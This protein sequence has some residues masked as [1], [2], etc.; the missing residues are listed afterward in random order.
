[1][2]A[3]IM[4]VLTFLLV[5]GFVV[6][7]LLIGNLEPPTAR[8]ADLETLKLRKKVLYKQIKEAE[9]EF[10]IGIL[11]DE[12]FAQTRN[13]LKKEV[14]QLISEIHMKSGK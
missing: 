7:P 10:E 4:T 3:M 12:D 6:Q 14:A 13:R 5:A 2:F 9:M 11:S 8:D 1:M